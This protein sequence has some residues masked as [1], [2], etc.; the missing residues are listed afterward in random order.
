[1]LPTL[2]IGAII[3]TSVRHYRDHEPVRGDI[4][5]FSPPRYPDDVWVQRVVG[6]PGDHIVYGGNQVSINGQPLAYQRTGIY[7]GRGRDAEMTGAIELREDL[8]DYPH[9]I[10]E[11][12]DSRFVDQ[13]EGAWKVPPGHYFLMGDNRDRSDDSRFSGTVP[14]EALRG[15]VIG[16]FDGF[17]DSP[18]TQSTQQ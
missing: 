15:K 9:A 13:G 1:M 7:Q 10:L 16:R 5:V 17:I 3:F 8:P 18:E 14:R 2:K 12:E 4:V 11:I 6:L